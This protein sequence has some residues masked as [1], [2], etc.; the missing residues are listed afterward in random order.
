MKLK[1]LL[2]LILMGIVGYMAYDYLTV[3][4]SQDA[5][6]YKRYMAA[7][8]DNNAQRVRQNVSGE[9]PMKGLEAHGYRLQYWNG[10][11]RWVTYNF[12]S[13]SLSPDGNTV[14][15]RVRQNVRVDPPGITTYWGKEER[16][17]IH[18]VVLV[19]ERSVW[20]VSYFE[21]SATRALDADMSRQR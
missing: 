6:A 12:L 16:R 13:R 11:P 14:R 20:K 21:D 8:I 9:Q 1:T 15:M 19:K 17:D 18:T 10:E 5:L 3:Q 4:L 7:I 2:L